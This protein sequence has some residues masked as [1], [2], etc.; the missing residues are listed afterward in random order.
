MNTLYIVIDAGEF[1]WSPQKY[2]SHFMS[3]IGLTKTEEIFHLCCEGVLNVTYTNDRSI[4]SLFTHLGGRFDINPEMVNVQVD[5]EVIF[6]FL[7]REL[8]L[9]GDSAPIILLKVMY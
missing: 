4:P 7:N 8:E 3:V 9:M 1:T 5:G 6:Y 2:G